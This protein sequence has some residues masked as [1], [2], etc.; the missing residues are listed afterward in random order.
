MLPFREF[1]EDFLNAIITIN[2]EEASERCIGPLLG[3][4]LLPFRSSGEPLEEALVVFPFSPPFFLP[5][6][7]P[8]ALFKVR[9]SATRGG[10]GG[11]S[12][13]ADRNARLFPPASRRIGYTSDAIFTIFMPDSRQSGR[14]VSR[15]YNRRRR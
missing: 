11:R 1:P 15:P 10:E 3:L 14:G 2:E 6:L 7:L 9:G 12:F 4:S 8:P 13:A 5:L